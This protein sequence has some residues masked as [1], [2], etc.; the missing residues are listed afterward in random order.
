[1]HQSHDNWIT[2]DAGTIPRRLL[3]IESLWEKPGCICMGHQLSYLYLPNHPRISP[4]DGTRFNLGPKKETPKQTEPTVAIRPSN[5]S[6]T[7]LPWSPP[8]SST[9]WIIFL[10]RFGNRVIWRGS[11][12]PPGF[13]IYIVKSRSESGWKLVAKILLR[14]RLC[15][16]TA[17]LSHAGEPISERRPMLYIDTW[18]VDLPLNDHNLILVLYFK[19][20]VD[21][22]IW[23]VFLHLFDDV[24]YQSSYL[25]DNIIW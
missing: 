23:F 8:V 16:G 10:R 6:G 1:M 2:S 25:E 18:M 7:H 13:Y 17:A 21:Q 20:V 19:C 12:S 5:H 14:I 3:N 9:K 4:I 24:G 22:C 15:R 11:G